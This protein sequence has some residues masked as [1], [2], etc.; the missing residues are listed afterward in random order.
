MVGVFKQ[1]RNLLPL[2]Y[3]G[4]LPGEGSPYREAIQGFL[5]LQPLLLKQSMVLP[6]IYY[7]NN[8]LCYLSGA[9]LKNQEGKA[10]LQ[11]IVSYN[12]PEK[13]LATYKKRW[14]I[15]TCFRAMKS[16][17]FNIEDTHL[18]HLDRKTICCNDHNSIC[19][20]LSSGNIQKSDDKT[21][22]NTKAWKKSKKHLQIWFRG[23]C[24]HIAKSLV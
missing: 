12:K 21:H 2:A 8:Q 19:M 10:E 3:T 15:E 20:G 18:I 14:Q 11:I 22:T 23:N 13:A 1:G 6:R 4:K 17:G 16:G 9:G 5:G 24:K 7:V